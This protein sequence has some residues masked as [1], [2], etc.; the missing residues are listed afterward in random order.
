MRS[1]R[2]A[3]FALALS[4]PAHAV[5]LLELERSVLAFTFVDASPVFTDT[6][7][8]GHESREAGVFLEAAVTSIGRGSLTNAIAE[9]SQDSE[10]SPGGSGLRVQGA[11][12]VGAA[13]DVADPGYP[14][15][16]EGA[17]DSALR[18]VF[19]L[20]EASAYSLGVALLADFAE[21]TIFSGTGPASGS[22]TAFAR[23][24]GA[25]GGVVADWSV[26]DALAD[27]STV[28]LSQSVGGVLA[29]DTYVLEIGAHSFAR[30]F[31][32]A[33]AFGAAG[34][35]FDLAILR[36]PPAALTFAAALALVTIA[37]RRRAR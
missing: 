8:V 27:G 23:L 6:E 11:G 1:I 14:S 18:I 33:A 28:S 31:E 5:T 10:V 2:S 22:F 13:F 15:R 17:G 16:A 21:L 12:S 35:G 30:G 3:L 34:F 29:A 24:T 9:A 25:A 7:S 37:L 20:D 4:T 19:T 36:E 32:D 26:T